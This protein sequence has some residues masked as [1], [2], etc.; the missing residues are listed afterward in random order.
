[1]EDLG[2]TRS[3]LTFPHMILKNLDDQSLTKCIGLCWISKEKSKLRTRQGTERLLWIE[4]VQKYIGNI[5]DYP[6]TW[7]SVVDDKTSLEIVKELALAVHQFFTFRQSR[8]QSPWT[9]LHIV[10]ERGNLKLSKYIIEKTGRKNPQRAD[11]LT[12]YHLAAQ[13]GHL[14]VSPEVTFEFS[15]S[16]FHDFCFC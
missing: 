15:S 4:I 2:S 6:D 12:P 9:P 7:G 11:G 8:Q 10:A 14:E 13:N 16:W 3:L 1:M 5:E